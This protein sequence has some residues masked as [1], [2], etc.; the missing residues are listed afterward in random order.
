[1]QRD[2]LSDERR[3][4][5]ITFD[6]GFASN[7][8]HA[9][10]ILAQFRLSG[11]HFLVTGELG[12]SNTWDD[13]GMP[14]YPLLSRADVL[15]ADPTLMTFHS[16]SATHASLTALDAAVLEREVCESKTQ[17]EALAGRAV[18]MFAY[19][20]GSWNPRVRAAVRSA[21]YRAAYSCRSGVMVPAPI[22]T[23]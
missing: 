16:H 7:V 2:S 23:F 9:W 20:F 1:M 6:D 19:P 3:T 11:D 17:L 10:P 14:R 8:Q 18:T 21:G 13:A 15:A 5:A 22:A 4:T 12:G